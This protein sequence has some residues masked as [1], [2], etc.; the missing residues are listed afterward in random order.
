VIP[1][2][3]CVLVCI[4]GIHTHTLRIR[5]QLFDDDLYDIELFFVFSGG[6]T[7]L[8]GPPSARSD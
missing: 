8:W 2:D 4:R 6:Q 3:S 1:R 7:W 5:E